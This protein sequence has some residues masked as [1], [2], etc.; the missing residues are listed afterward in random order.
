MATFNFGIGIQV[1]GSAADEVNRLVGALTD[2]DTRLGRIQGQGN[3][4]DAMTQGL[5]GA[6]RAAV[7]AATA[8]AGVAASASSLATGAPPVDAYANLVTIFRQIGAASSET[9]AAAAAAFADAAENAR[10]AAAIEITST[11]STTAAVTTLTEATTAGGVVG[12]VTAKEVASELAKQGKAAEETA[13]RTFSIQRAFS[14]VRSGFSQVVSGAIG[15]ASSIGN[16]VT[17]M[18]GSKIE[19]DLT[20]MGAQMGVNKAQA[21]AWWQ[22]TIDLS[23][24]MGLPPEAISQTRQAIAAAG[25]DFDKL[26][27]AE[28]QAASYMTAVFEI[29]PAVVA[30]AVG[31]ANRLGV[32]F[33]D[34]ADQSLALSKVSGVPDLIRELPEAM[35]FAS[36]MQARFSTQVSKSGRSIT[37]DIQRMTAFYSKALGKTAPEAARLAQGTFERFTGAVTANRDV[38]LGLGDDFD[39]LT[40]AF[41]ETGRSYDEIQGLLAGAKGDPRGF[42]LEIKRIQDSLDPF[43]AERFTRQVTQSVDEGTASLL[44][45]SRTQLMNQEEV[46]DK[47]KA[48]AAARQ[49]ATD[50]AIRANQA[51]VTDAMRKQSKE[52]REVAEGMQ[53][54]VIASVARVSSSVE[55]AV[56]QFRK[57]ASPGIQKGM[58]DLV[59]KINHIVD[60][61]TKFMDE[62]TPARIKQ[63][64]DAIAN[65]SEAAVGAGIAFAAFG[66]VSPIISGVS[67]VLS[68]LWTVVSAAPLAAAAK[69]LTSFV[70]SL[71]DVSLWSGSTTQILGQLAL[72]AALVV[73][74]AKPLNDH[75]QRMDS[76]FGST[77]DSGT[78]LGVVLGSTL[79]G[80][81]DLLNNLL[82]GIPGKLLG[83]NE[84]FGGL[85]KTIG[86]TFSGFP[87]M[88]GEFVGGLPAKLGAAMRD[89]GAE[90]IKTLATLPTLIIGVFQTGF[91]I[92]ADMLK[93]LVKGIFKSFDADPSTLLKIDQFFDYLKLGYTEVANVARLIFRTVFGVLGEGLARIFDFI[94]A[95][96]KASTIRG[97]VTD[98]ADKTVEEEKQLQAL[99]DRMDKRTI[100]ISKAQGDEAKAKGQPAEDAAAQ[101]KREADLREATASHIQLARE[102]LG[103]NAAFQSEASLAQI[104]ANYAI[105]AQLARRTL[106]NPVAD[107]AS[108]KSLVGIGSNLQQQQQ[109]QQ[110]RQQQ[111]QAQTPAVEPAAPTGT[112]PTGVP[113]QVADKSG[114]TLPA[115]AVATGPSTAERVAMTFQVVVNATDAATALHRAVADALRQ[116]KMDVMNPAMVGH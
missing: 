54:N 69:N 66:V 113:A 89:A 85:S 44:S 80:G 11:E 4:F 12:V 35:N 83:M 101:V 75:I 102:V 100:D 2:L 110:Q 84:G 57:F 21:D 10:A 93:G 13:K 36:Q 109:Q 41:M 76:V 96:T 25:V 40:K 42:A 111:Q 99:K 51:P 82:G 7:D 60:S 15:V 28:R 38:F 33:T 29:D 46:D 19:R 31:S 91:E 95:T 98:M 92:G 108:D 30:S 112:A 74:G 53:K 6:Q 115:Q 48:L 27:D 88:L 55:A 49:K 1:E 61:I 34:L 94:G 3:V 56:E 103:P 17:S 73:E 9:G 68:G 5:I 106:H 78:K 37:T 47:L 22:S 104:G 70:G 20:R 116:L 32:S 87:E 86:D 39:P 64:E 97:F 105:Q 24:A 14:Q 52:M 59:P 45:L 72:G 58:E 114:V 79:G 50:D 107:A 43:M 62:L 71:M 63:V 26:T 8:L 77:A 81:L 90:I 16:I 18:A 65:I 23:Q 67:T